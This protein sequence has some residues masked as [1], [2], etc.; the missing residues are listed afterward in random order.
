MPRPCV[1]TLVARHP[2]GKRIKAIC[3]LHSR[4]V[5]LQRLN[6]IP[7]RDYPYFF[8]SGLTAPFICPLTVAKSYAHEPA[9]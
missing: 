2:K 4:D 8:K 1:F 6:A 5:N 3:L 9:I 7:V